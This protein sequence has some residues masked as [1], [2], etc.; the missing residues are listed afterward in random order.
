[1]RYESF[2]FWEWMGT[3]K[4]RESGEV[5]ARTLVSLSKLTTEMILDF[6]QWEKNYICEKNLNNN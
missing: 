6:E 2:A 5:P 1:M 4:R 3:D